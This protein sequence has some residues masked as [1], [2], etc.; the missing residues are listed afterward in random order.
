MSE[1]GDTDRVGRGRLMLREIGII[2]ASILIAF[3]VDR[4]WDSWRRGRDVA[5]LRSALLAEFEG[6]RAESEAQARRNLAVIAAADTLLDAFSVGTDTVRVSARTVDALL[7]T[8]TTDPP[9]GALTAWL[10]SGDLDLV[11]DRALQVALAG[12]PAV[13]DD[14]REEELAAAR[15]VSEVLMTELAY[16]D[17]IGPVLDSRFDGPSDVIVRLPVTNRVKNLV[18]IR[19]F[20]SRFVLREREKLMDAATYIVR[21]LEG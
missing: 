5:E 20:F 21:E 9:G 10:A 1:Q 16:L 14:S 7:Y 8:P 6:L 17:D 12:F 2:V 15:F 3:S 13:V 19:R 18:E 11:P 4:S